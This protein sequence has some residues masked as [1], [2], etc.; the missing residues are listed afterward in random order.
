MGSK[1]DWIAKADFKAKPED[2]NIDKAWAEARVW[3]NN[4]GVSTS[5][6]PD[7]EKIRA[8]MAKAKKGMEFTAKWDGKWVEIEATVGGKTVDKLVSQ[9][10]SEGGDQ[11]K[12]RNGMVKLRQFGGVLVTDADLKAFDARHPD[13]DAT[14][15]HKSR[16]DALGREIKMLNIQIQRLQVELKPKLEELLQ[17]QKTVK[18]LGG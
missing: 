18:A 1:S 12:W 9:D 5:S 13:P 2:I 4:V 11:K 8:A 6:K 14:A 10:L 15:K 3:M 16:I 7:V 17:L